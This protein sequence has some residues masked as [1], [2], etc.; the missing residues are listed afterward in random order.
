[1]D[2][3]EAG[4]AHE[5]WEISCEVPEAVRCPQGPVCPHLNLR[6]LL[7]LKR[8]GT[9]ARVFQSHCGVGVGGECSHVNAQLSKPGPCVDFMAYNLAPPVLPL[10]F[11]FTHLPPRSK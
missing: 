8:C 9:S 3:K 5:S 2:P 10:D 11:V 1:M 7:I 6:V 4:R